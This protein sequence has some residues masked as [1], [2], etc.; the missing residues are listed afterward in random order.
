MGDPDRTAFFCQPNK[1]FCRPNRFFCCS[2]GS[3]GTMTTAMHLAASRGQV[4]VLEWLLARGGE[5]GPPNM[6]NWKKEKRKLGEP[7]SPHHMAALHGHIPALEVLA[8]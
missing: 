6:E 8:A 3:N 7:P 5:V 2:R 4:P 1:V